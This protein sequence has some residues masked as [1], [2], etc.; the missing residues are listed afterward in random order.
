M[1]RSPADHLMWSNQD[2]QP[3]C[4]IL[5]RSI[6]SFARSSFNREVP[7]SIPGRGRVQ[8]FI[9]AL[10]YFGDVYITVR[11]NI[12]L[13]NWRG[14]AILLTHTFVTF[15][16]IGFESLRQSRLLI[17]DWC[18]PWMN[19]KVGKLHIVL[20]VKIH[21]KVIF[22]QNWHF[23][24]FEMFMSA[25]KYIQSFNFKQRTEIWKKKKNSEASQMKN[26]WVPEL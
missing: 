12:L 6:S 25:S 15:E 2:Y 19:H 26:I 9:S 11:D 1:Q 7:G 17:C 23:R 24:R 3:D 8:I 22:L 5:S 18:T 21:A 10:V 20:Q 13:I 14:G 4:L 16:Y